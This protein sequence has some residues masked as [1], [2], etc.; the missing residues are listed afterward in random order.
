MQAAATQASSISSFHT[1]AGLEGLPA[2]ITVGAHPSATRHI[3][4]LVWTVNME[5]ILVTMDETLEGATYAWIELELPDLGVIRPLMR[6]EEQDGDNV[7]FTY[8][9]LFPQD[10]ELL[11]RSL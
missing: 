9:H 4:A 2:V 7:W 6:I 11:R 8:R 1:D 10:R 5:G 3:E